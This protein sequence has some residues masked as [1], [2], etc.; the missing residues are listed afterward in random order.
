MY[1]SRPSNGRCPNQQAVWGWCPK[2]QFPSAGR[3]PHVSSHGRY[4]S[5][6]APTQ[7]RSSLK[8]GSQTRGPPLSTIPQ[9][10]YENQPPEEGNKQKK[11]LPRSKSTQRAPV[12][13]IRRKKKEK[14]RIDVLLRS[15]HADARVRGCGRRLAYF[16]NQ[17]QKK[18]KKRKKRKKV[19]WL[20]LS[21]LPSDQSS[22]NARQRGRNREEN[23]GKARGIVSRACVSRRKFPHAN[24]FESPQEEAAAPD[25]FFPASVGAKSTQKRSVFSRMSAFK[26]E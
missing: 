4:R 1:V 15:M 5:R 23:M 9:C 22:S 21:D 8:P 13:L 6:Q 25:A 24:A 17:F 7:A 10:A 11:H 16:S 19:R 3:I 26:I 12:I 18:K 14:S 2:R 20:A